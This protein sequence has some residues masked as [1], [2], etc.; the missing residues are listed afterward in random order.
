MCPCVH[1]P[2]FEDVTID[3]N[4]V[5]EKVSAEYITPTFL[6]CLLTGLRNAPLIVKKE[7]ITPECITYKNLH[8]VCVPYN[9]LGSSV[10]L[11]CIEKD[12]P[13]LCNS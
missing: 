10:V 4:I 13:C 6:P 8:S 11:D 7:N 12:I 1:A 2:A 5:D 9:A 3:G